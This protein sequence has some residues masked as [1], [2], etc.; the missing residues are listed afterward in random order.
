[1]FVDFSF[2]SWRH[3]DVWNGTGRWLAKVVGNCPH[4]LFGEDIQMSARR[5]NSAANCDGP[6]ASLVQ[7][8]FAHGALVGVLEGRN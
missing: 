1:V 6:S 7:R 2:G 8:F 4:Q 5:L 3:N